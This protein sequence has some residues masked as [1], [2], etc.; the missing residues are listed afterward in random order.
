MKTLLAILLFAIP[1]AAQDARVLP[2]SP[3]DAQTAKAK[4][5]ALQKAQKDWDDFQE[6]IKQ[7]YLVVPKG[8]PEAGNTI[9]SGG[10]TSWAGISYSDGSYVVKSA[11]EKENDERK[12]PTMFERAGWENGAVFTKDFRFL[13][14][15]P[16]PEVKQ[17][18]FYVNGSTP[19]V[20][21]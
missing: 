19:M 18:P 11:V 13:V 16:S 17:N 8:D 2:L 3:V 15:K 6:K 4:Y 10:L 1:L 20:T 5:E 21:W 12:H 9:A 14:P 7:D